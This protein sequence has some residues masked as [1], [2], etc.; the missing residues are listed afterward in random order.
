[1]IKQIIIVDSYFHRAE[2]EV[3]NTSIV[4]ML[5]SQGFTIT[6]YAS[7]SSIDNLKKILLEQNKKNVLDCISFKKIYIASA[8]SSDLKRTFISALYNIWFMLKSKSNTILLF[9]YNNYLSI[10]ATN[11][12]SKLLQK[13]IITCCH[14]EMESLK[15]ARPGKVALRHRLLNDFFKRRNI[16][17]KSRFVVFGDSIKKNLEVLLSE[18]TSNYFIAIDHPYFAFDLSEKKANPRNTELNLG[19][20]GV[21]K[22]EKG[23][24][25]LLLFANTIQNHVK[26]AKVR[27]VTISKVVGNLDELE[28]LGIEIMNNGAS[29]L[30][31]QEYTTAVR[32]MDF[33]FFP[34][35]RNSYGLTASGAVFESIFSEKPIL[36]LRN[37]FFSYLFNKYAPFGILCNSEE[38]LRKTVDQI[39]A[40]TIHKDDFTQNIKQIKKQLHPEQ[41]G[42]IFSSHLQKNYSNNIGS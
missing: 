24:K 41:L 6:Y 25:N 40:G 5:A 33:I 18:K 29:L 14:A 21:V 15:Q 36:A 22:K 32:D 12:L 27:L 9:N 38:E 11:I 23:L 2:H 10:H 34:Y 28:Q 20:V 26:Q 30:S 16:S 1:M 31:R 7:L 13:N 42:K 8:N 35:E 19:V 37:D 4:W 17:N 3:I 39:L